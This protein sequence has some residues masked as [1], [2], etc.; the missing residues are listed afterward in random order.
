MDEVGY[1][2]ARNLSSHSCGEDGNMSSDM[3]YGNGSG[4]IKMAV[5]ENDAIHFVRW[6]MNWEAWFSIHHH[7]VVDKNL[8]V[9]SSHRDG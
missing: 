1:Q 8:S 9:A 2:K 7:S 4:V 5:G 6:D 3:E